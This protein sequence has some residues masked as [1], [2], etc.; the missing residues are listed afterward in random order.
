MR[1]GVKIFLAISVFLLFGSSFTF[2]EGFRPSIAVPDDI[3]FQDLEKDTLEQVLQEVKEIKQEL[4]ELTVEYKKATKDTTDYIFVS[5]K[6]WSKTTTNLTAS[7]IIIDDLEDNYFFMI[8]YLYPPTELTDTKDLPKDTASISYREFNI[9]GSANWLPI[10]WNNFDSVKDY[11]KLGLDF[12]FG[13]YFNWQAG[14]RIKNHEV[15]LGL[16]IEIPDPV[17]NLEDGLG[18][19]I[20]MVGTISHA[21][22]V[23]GCRATAD[24]SACFLTGGARF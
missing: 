10:R 12:G 23:S 18:F 15:G 9:Q 19:Q 2:A 16:D 24:Y 8:G 17:V 5:G 4:K 21:V 3:D 7:F 13:F 6:Q 14:L 20:L 22:I 11:C 1:K